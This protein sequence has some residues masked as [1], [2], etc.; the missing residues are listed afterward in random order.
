MRVVS[1]IDIRRPAAEVFEYVSDQLNAPAWQQG[2]DEVRRTTDGPIGVGARHTFVR[3]VGRRRVSGENV[4]VEFEPGRRVVFT[5]TSDGLTGKGWYEVSPLGVNETRLDSGVEIT[6]TGPARL[7][8]P[9]IARSI[10]K[11]DSEDTAHL[12]QILEQAGATA[13][14]PAS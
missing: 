6:L 12:K 7:A 9:L 11:E 8:A 13:A 1:R 2:L 14:E 4:Y 10:R 3:S 5:F